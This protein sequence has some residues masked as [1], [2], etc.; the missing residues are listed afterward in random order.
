MKRACLYVTT[1]LIN[2][3]KYIGQTTSTRKGYLGSGKVITAAIKKYG[4][5]NFVR[6]DL[7]EDEWEFIDLLEH[8]YIQKCGAVESTLYY[9]Q[10]PGGHTSTHSDKTRQIMSEKAKLRSESPENRKKR[11]E[12][13]TGP[14]NHFYKKTHSDASKEKI[15]QARSLQIITPESNIK[16]SATMTGRKKEITTCPHCGLI[17]GKGNLVRYHFDNCK[18]QK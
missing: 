3:K 16:R 13:M 15:K 6:E 4:K 2:G 8:E 18:G 7:Y 10:K 11:S 14:G 1:N 5:E 12:R 17:G 9:N